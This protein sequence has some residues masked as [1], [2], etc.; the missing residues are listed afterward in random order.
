MAGGGGLGAGGR[1]RGS[2]GLAWCLCLW[3]GDRRHRGEE[4]AR[5]MPNTTDGE[6][7]KMQIPQRTRSQKRPCVG[8]GQGN[9]PAFPGTP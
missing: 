7:N 1:G 4:S 9:T 2:K 5:K 6:Q 3:S 8:D